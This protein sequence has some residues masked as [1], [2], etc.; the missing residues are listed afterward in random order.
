M[1]PL[2]LAGQTPAES[3]SASGIFPDEFSSLYHTGEVSGKL[4]ESLLRARVYFAEQGA[5][6]LKTF[7]MLPAARSSARSCCWSPGR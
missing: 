5:R 2:W 1:K 3:V 7:V 6:K 4:D